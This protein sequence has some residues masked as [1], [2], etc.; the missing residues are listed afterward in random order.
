ME[1]NLAILFVFYWV[2]IFSCLGYGKLVSKYVLNNGNFENYGY[3]GLLGVLSIII[4]AYISNFFYTHNQLHNS[5]FILIGFL[6]F[7]YFAYSGDFE[8]KKIISLLVIF[9]I[10]FISFIIY[11]PH[12]DFSYYHFQ[13]SYYLTQFPMII[14][15]GQFNHGFATPSSI[16]YFN[17]LFFLPLAGYSLFHISVVLVMGFSNIIL[18]EKLFRHLKKEDP[19]YLTYYLLLSLA[20]INIIFYRLAEHGTDRSAQI[21]IFILVFE[22]ILLINYRNNFDILLSKIFILISLIISFKVFYILYFL[23]LFPVFFLWI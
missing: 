8:K 10:F 9:L 3:V 22:L 4:Y 13:Y 19:N 1:L 23:F 14:G 7:L 2:S 21:L 17:S 5:L 12:D 15:V 20:F 6:S 16:F 11:K 18:I